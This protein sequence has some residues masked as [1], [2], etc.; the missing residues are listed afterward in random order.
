[1]IKVDT[2]QWDYGLIDGMFTPEEVDLIKSIPLSRCKAEDTLFWPFTSNG[3]YTSK[4][5]YRF[6]KSE[7]QI[8]IDE[9]QRAHD[10]ELW[11]TIWSLQVLNKIKNLVVEGMP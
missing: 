7:E 6:L 2:R 1:M 5:G 9:E 4:S 11:Q 3:I 10:K 8:E